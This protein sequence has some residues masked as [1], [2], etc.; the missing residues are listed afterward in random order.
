MSFFQLLTPTGQVIGSAGSLTDVASV[1]RNAKPGRY[2][3]QA[4]SPTPFSSGHWLAPWGTAVRD[5]VGR[6]TLEPI[7][8]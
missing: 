6:V 5:D 2:R 8:N 7:I 3:I 1:L 4:V